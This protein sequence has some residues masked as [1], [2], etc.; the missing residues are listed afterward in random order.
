[1]DTHPRCCCYRGTSTGGGGC[2]LSFHPCQ[3]NRS[4]SVVSPQRLLPVLS[5]PSLRRLSAVCTAYLSVSLF[6]I[7]DPTLP[8]L[9]AL[10]AGV[11]SAACRTAF[12]ARARVAI[13]ATGAAFARAAPRQSRKLSG[14]AVFLSR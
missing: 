4:P 14:L 3:D 8:V 10:V 1:A 6:W 5:P 12:E 7:A 11:F 9:L 2:R 13:L